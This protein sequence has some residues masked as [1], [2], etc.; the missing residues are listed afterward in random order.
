VLNTVLCLARAAKHTFVSVTEP[1]LEATVSAPAVCNCSEDTGTN[2]RGE[3]LFELIEIFMTS[4][5]CLIE[6]SGN[7]PAKRHFTVF[8]PFTPSFDIVPNPL[9]WIR[10]V[11]IID[12]LGHNFLKQLALFLH[13]FCGPRARAASDLPPYPF[14]SDIVSG[15]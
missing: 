7:A 13:H 2:A 8:L 15:S 12:G 5:G 3:N 14:D 10:A 4:T 11:F 9:N 6:G 1:L